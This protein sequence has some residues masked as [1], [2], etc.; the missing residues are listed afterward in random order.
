MDESGK[1]SIRT[2]ARARPT[3]WRVSPKNEYKTGCPEGYPYIECCRQYRVWTAKTDVVMRRIHRAGE[4]VFVDYAGQTIS[5]V[6]R[7]TGELRPAVIFAAVL[8]A[9]HSATKS[10]RPRGPTEHQ[11][12]AGSR[13]RG[14]H[15]HLSGTSTSS[16]R[17]LGEDCHARHSMPRP[18]QA[19]AS[20]LFLAPAASRRCRLERVEDRHPRRFKIA[21]IPGDHG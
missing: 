21:L 12:G 3:S 6:D 8:G 9:S 11:S 18:E 14:G 13:A 1:C 20:R 17:L 16:P 7:H 15:G 2:V 19:I 5:I 4:T 10:A